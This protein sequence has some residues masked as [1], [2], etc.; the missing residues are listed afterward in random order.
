MHRPGIWMTARTA[1]DDPTHWTLDAIA[2][3]RLLAVNGRLDAGGDARR[4][5]AALRRRPPWRRVEGEVRRYRPERKLRSDQRTRYALVV[6][7]VRDAKKRHQFRLPPLVHAYVEM[8]A[9][10]WADAGAGACG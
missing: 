3:R 10:A 6:I 2:A 4:G 9:A 5:T 1:D 8:M 7:V